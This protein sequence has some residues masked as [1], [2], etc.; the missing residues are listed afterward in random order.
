MSLFS[1][2]RLTIRSLRRQPLFALTVVAI[3]AVAVGANTAIFSLFNS[4]F[5]EPLPFPHPERVVDLNERAPEW[6]L[7]RVSV[8]YPDIDAWRAENRTFD[9]LAPWDDRSF[10]LSLEGQAERVSGIAVG[11]NFGEV[12]GYQP[13]L[14]RDFIEADDQ[15]GAAKVV[16]LG[17]G[18]WQR[19]YGADPDVLSQTLRLDGQPHTIIGV[20]P[21]DAL[22]PPR[23]DLWVPLAL[24]PDHDDG[25]YLAGIG[26]LAEGVSADQ[27]LADLT[28]I[29][30][31]LIDT[32]PQ[33][34]I[35][36]PTITPMR[37]LI[38]GDYELAVAL[39]GGA[40]I[41]VLLIACANIAGL[42]LARGSARSR[43]VAIR[44]ALGAS[45]VRIV[46]QLL[47]ES[48]MLAVVGVGLGTWL[49]YRAVQLLPRLS[50]VQLPAWVTFELD[51]PFLL[52]SVV[53][54]VGTALL[55]GMVP[56]LDAT[57]TSLRCSLHDAS[58]RASD[59]PRQRRTLATLVMSEVALALLLLV[60]AG[61][62]IKLSRRSTSCS[63]LTP[64]TGPRMC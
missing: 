60:T 18:L 45:R 33:N 62:L 22:F 11:H 41:V 39:L 25:W 20:L 37:E 30:R 2:L 9:G 27:A 53:T 51:L 43:E 40:V 24:P 34:E 36:S 32:R 5:L 49:G 14:G 6:N 52:F 63:G 46:R 3:L 1:D 13:M 35:T 57:R 28:S 10:N 56:A 58:I 17:H 21:P 15:P 7:E 50:P 48:L 31:G 61:L 23:A 47:T 42:L 44:A 19:R 29:H 8:A 12:V 55:F 64:A 4:L 38:F 54:T 59:T 26:R 16:I